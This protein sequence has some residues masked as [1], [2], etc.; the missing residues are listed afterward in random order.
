MK[1]LLSS[2]FFLMLAATSVMAQEHSGWSRAELISKTKE[3]S[4]QEVLEVKSLKGSPG[5]MQLLDPTEKPECFL[6]PEERWE[7]F[8]AG[9]F[10]WISMIGDMNRVHTLWL[11]F[12]IVNVGDPDN[13]IAFYNKFFSYLFPEWQ[14]ASSWA[15]DSL[16]ASLSAAGKAYD[17]PMI[18]FDEMIARQTVNGAALATTGVPPDIVYYRITSRAGCEKVSDYL[19]AKPRR[20]KADPAKRE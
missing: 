4:N 10:S 12:P 15:M 9:D 3:L 7:S 18:S 2:I 19:L 17:D 8:S 11:T 14:G 6:G 13:A 20:E 1:K 16:I 5:G